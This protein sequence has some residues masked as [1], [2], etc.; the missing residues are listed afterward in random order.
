MA[1]QRPLADQADQA[2]Q[3]NQATQA[4]QIEPEL[5]T[6]FNGLALVYPGSLYPH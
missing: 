5:D 3:A 1:N 2:D 4:D 6:D